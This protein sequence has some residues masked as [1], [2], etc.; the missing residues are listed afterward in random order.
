MRGKEKRKAKTTLLAPM[1]QSSRKWNRR[2]CRILTRALCF[3]LLFGSFS[4]SF[5]H[6]AKDQPSQATA[7]ES[8]LPDIEARPFPAAIIKRSRSLRVYL[9][10]DESG[11]LPRTGK[12]VLLKRN[13]TPVMAFRVLKQYPGQGQFAAKRVRTYENQRSLEEGEHYLGIEKL[14]DILLSG[15]SAAERRSDSSDLAELE[16]TVAEF[17]PELDAATSQPVDETPEKNEG[18]LTEIKPEEE[19]EEDLN[20]GDVVAFEVL[21]FDPDRQWATIIQAALIRNAATVDGVGAETTDSTAI[22]GNSTYYS[23]LGVRYGFSLLKEFFLYNSFV[24]DSLAAELGLFGYKVVGFKASDDSFTVLPLIL[25]LRYNFVFSPG[26]MVSVYGG[27]VKNFIF[28]SNVNDPDSEAALGGIL[29]AAG[30]GL[31]FR[32]G[33]KWFI[34]LDAGIDLLAGG[35]T[36]RF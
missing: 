21:P 30:F 12:I 8:A 34:R 22:F 1:T 19:E 20:V 35:L 5:V 16:Q 2:F 36:L 27:L 11:D 6:A 3:A 4:L 18:E 10:R 14:K 31:Y 15:E 24:Q 32:I 33:P 26:F 28:D 23:G 17:D 9:I 7:A 25:T 29:P 13:N